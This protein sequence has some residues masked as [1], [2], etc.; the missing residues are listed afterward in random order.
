VVIAIIGILV[1][2]LLPA[3]QAARESARRM[4]CQN[5][6][7]Q[8][9]LAT[10]N[11]HDVRKHLPPPKVIVP[12]AVYEDPVTYV[13]LGS[14][15][16]VLLPY[17]EEAN[18]YASYDLA[19]LVTDPHNIPY[20]GGPIDTYLCPSMQLPRDVPQTVCGEVLG[21]G[22]YM[23]SAHTDKPNDVLNGAFANPQSKR[24]AGNQYVVEPYTLGLQQ[25]L[26]GTSKTI[27]L[28]EA[29][30]GIQEFEW[31]ERCPQLAGSPRWGDQTWA[32]GYWIYS[33]GH[34]DWRAYEKSGLRSYNASTMVTEYSRTMRVFRSDH[35][36]GAQFVFL[37]GSVRFVPETVE[38]PV[39][40]ALVT[41]A[42]GETDHQ[43]E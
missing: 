9:G 19:K 16:V 13:N 42:G 25:I 4:T 35:P 38:Y 27:L 15:L 32:E 40:R 34:I 3:I 39:L 7:R 29:N 24:T 2:I 18:R 22:S 23:I 8:I 5:N 33:W 31:D 26:D 41:R 6:L 11:F 20:T 14:T 1:A 17:L 10:L 30:Y 37:D 21:P 28:G 36:G 43:F 12:G